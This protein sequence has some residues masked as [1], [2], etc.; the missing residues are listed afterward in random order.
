LILV[1]FTALILFLK[2]GRRKREL[3]HTRRG[4][5]MFIT[6]KELPGGKKREK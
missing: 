5:C 4:V 2:E 3:T 6:T 1:V